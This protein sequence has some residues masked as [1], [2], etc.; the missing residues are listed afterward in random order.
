MVRTSSSAFGGW[1]LAGNRSVYHHRSPTPKIGSFSQMSMES[2][3][4][5]IRWNTELNWLPELTWSR[6]T[7]ATRASPPAPART[8]SFERRRVSSVRS[9]TR[10]TETASAT[11]ACRDWV[12]SMPPV[13]SMNAL[14]AIHRGH[15][16]HG[17]F[18]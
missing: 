17:G 8:S 5:L 12:K 18:T 6:T 10:A 15:L 4:Q 14:R 16:I 13:Q 7:V 11:M 3:S 1:N 9:T 2:C